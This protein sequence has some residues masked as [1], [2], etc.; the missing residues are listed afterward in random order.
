ML[1][2]DAT[3]NAV[4]N[5]TVTFSVPNAG[6]LASP[7]WVTPACPFRIPY[8]ADAQVHPG[9]A[10][11]EVTGVTGPLG[12]TFALFL[13]SA[14]DGVQDPWIATAGSLTFS[15][16][17][18]TMQLQ[19]TAGPNDSWPS[20]TIAL[21]TNVND[22]GARLI[23]QDDP[24]FFSV[25]GH[26]CDDGQETCPWRSP[27]IATTTNGDFP[28]TLQFS[29]AAGSTWRHAA[30]PPSTTGEVE[31]YF[32]LGDT[33][34]D[35][36]TIKTI[37]TTSTEYPPDSVINMAVAE[38]KLE[39]EMQPHG[40]TFLEPARSNDRTIDTFAEVQELRAIVRYTRN[41]KRGAF[42]VRDP[43][44]TRVR[45]VQLTPEELA[46]DGRSLTGADG[47]PAAVVSDFRPDNAG[48]PV[49]GTFALTFAR[50]VTPGT[51]FELSR[52]CEEPFD[53]L[54]GG[55]LLVEKPDGSLLDLTD[56]TRVS[57][58]ALSVDQWVDVD[59]DAK[60][61]WA[62]AVIDRAFRAS[63]RGEKEREILTWFSPT[64]D[65]LLRTQ[66]AIGA[67]N[68]SGTRMSFNPALRAS[69]RENSRS[70]SFPR[71]FALPDSFLV[72]NVLDSAVRHEGRHRWQVFVNDIMCFSC[73]RNAVDAFPQEANDSDHDRLPERPLRPKTLSP[74]TT[75]GDR[76]MEDALSPIS[77]VPLVD[78]DDV[79][80]TV[81]F[82]EP[83]QLIY[84][85]EVDAFDFEVSL[86]E[87]RNPC[88]P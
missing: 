44:G 32:R 53:P 66:D 22:T 52:I 63:G 28:L 38:V 26:Y 8:R 43:S 62:T 33:V 46:Y 10:V 29:A 83:V 11:T 37:W 69:A 4:A 86:E 36:A 21:T 87:A 74:F 3:G 20:N 7:A 50:S 51:C 78:I 5:V 49:I 75:E 64:Y 54:V 47:S 45:F 23:E 88:V 56:E 25:A 14:H 6:D 40:P 70:C 39:V 85:H 84:W 27:R 42:R 77:R 24:W 2:R 41:S 9:C 80:P 81:P 16:H 79:N 19:D 55:R 34:S 13:H 48:V 15:G 30:L 31:N 18:D 68:F 1:V 67:T 72:K 60:T 61:D 57:V 35:I 65:T 82:P 17:R 71:D 59:A 12:R 58:T 76:I 73:T